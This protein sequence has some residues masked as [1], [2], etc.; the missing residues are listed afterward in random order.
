[1]GRFGSILTLY[2]KISYNWIKDL[3]VR[4]KNIKPLEDN[5]GKTNFDIG[6]SNISLDLSQAR[7]TTAN[8]WA[9]KQKSCTSKETIDKMKRQP[10]EWEKICAN[11]ITKRLIF[12]IHI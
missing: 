1:M 11:N 10:M 12:K 6:L 3:N 8:K 9:I 4:P 2:T 5:T 7:K